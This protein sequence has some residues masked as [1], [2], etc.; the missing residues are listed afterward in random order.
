MSNTIIIRNAD[1]DP[2]GANFSGIARSP[3]E[4]D[5]KRYFLVRLDPELA[6]E[7]SSNGWNVKWTKPRPE[8]QGYEPYPYIKVNINY[9]LRKKPSVFLVSKNNRTLLSE[10]ELDILDGC[11]FENV[12][13]QISN[14]YYSYYDQWSIVLDVGFFTKEANELMDEYFPNGY[15][16]IIDEED[17]DIPFN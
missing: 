8:I 11:Y 15:A 2:R 6:D 16:P 1:V 5:G 9:K 14:I 13:L 10:S 4:Q 12:D 17:D 3:K 7:L